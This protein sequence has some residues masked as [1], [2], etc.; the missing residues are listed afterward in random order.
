MELILRAA[1]RDSA[2]GD[3]FLRI[4]HYTATVA[5]VENGDRH[6]LHWKAGRANACGG[7]EY[8]LRDGRLPPDASFAESQAEAEAAIHQLYRASLSSKDAHG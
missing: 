6:G 4:H 2:G 7:I 5:Y 8:A 1:W 3:R